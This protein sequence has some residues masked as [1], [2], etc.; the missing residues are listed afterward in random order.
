M[1]LTRSV[2]RHT[3]VYSIATI[4]GKLSGFFMLPFYAHYFQTEGYGIIAMI[5]ASLGVLTIL[6]A[7]GMQ[8]AIL[9]IY[10]EK[11]EELKYS[12]LGTGLFLVWGLVIIL[13]TFPILFSA[14]LSN[15][16]LD[17]PDYYILIILSLFSFIADVTGQSAST[18]LIIR[19]Q[20][21]RERKDRR[22]NIELIVKGQVIKYC[23]K[24]THS[25][26]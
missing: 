6:L 13:S 9:R 19:I 26:Y 17:T 3:A 12:T 14:P 23:I 21:K 15:I 25:D 7:G 16:I 4:I 8:T 20:K 10:H 24:H 18:F 2:F 22:V 11:P 5:E 1:K